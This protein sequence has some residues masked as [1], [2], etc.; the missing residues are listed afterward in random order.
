LVDYI[1]NREPF[2]KAEMENHNGEGGGWKMTRSDAKTIY[3]ITMHMGKPE[4]TYPEY[5]PS[6]KLKSFR[7]TLEEI[8]NFM[9][10]NDRKGFEKVSKIV[11]SQNKNNPRGSFLSRVLQKRENEILQKT[12]IPYLQKNGYVTGSMIFDGCMVFRK[13]GDV[14]FPK[15]IINGYAESVGLPEYMKITCKPMVDLTETVDTLFVKYRAI[16]HAFTKKNDLVLGDKVAGLLGMDI[17]TSFDNNGKVW[18][19]YQYNQDVHVWEET[20]HD[21]VLR[22]AMEKLRPIYSE[23]LFYLNWIAKSSPVHL[24]LALDKILK[25]LDDGVKKQLPK[26]EKI[27]DLGPIMGRMLDLVPEKKSHYVDLFF[28]YLKIK[29]EVDLGLFGLDRFLSDN[30]W[31]TQAMT[32]ILKIAKSSPKIRIDNFLEKVDCTP[33][34]LPLAS[35]KTVDLRDG[36]EISTRTLNEKG[37]YFTRY[38]KAKGLGKAD[39]ID[40][41]IKSHFMPDDEDR[42]YLQTQLGFCLTGE[43]VN[44]NLFVWLGDG[45]NGK[46]VL[47]AM[48]RTV[49][50]YACSLP[51]QD[52]I[53]MTGLDATRKGA[54]HSTTLI[55]LKFNRLAT[56][57]EPPKG[58]HF[59]S[60]KIKVLTGGDPLT[61]RDLHQ[62][63]RGSEFVNTCKLIIYTN[64]ILGSDNDNA[65]TDRVRYLN[66]PYRYVDTLTDGEDFEILKNGEKFTDQHSNEDLLGWLVEGARRY[67]SEGLQV[68]EETQKRM[69]SKMQESD[70]LREYMDLHY[71][72]LKGR[73]VKIIDILKGLKYADRSLQ[74]LN[75]RKIGAALR[76]I[77]GKEAVRKGHSGYLYLYDVMRNEDYGNE[78]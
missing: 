3:L 64:D 65:M 66:F 33:H 11:D 17:R 75:S 10:K 63:A 42:R 8:V 58:A 19:F 6:E 12:L 62:K 9:I 78:S 14:D 21:T 53:S 28:R 47:M 56:T 40:S 60:E 1:D 35:G 51:W 43:P 69:D 70:P 61:A 73:M 25:H 24:Q 30:I 7:E 50:P 20:S 2:L 34:L 76:R 39:R 23:M 4:N 27:K 55:P 5:I 26:I 54:E 46:S 15:K 77:Y 52:I 72:V 67:Y 71:K 45:G 59:I 74:N 36:S 37:I 32:R 13:S 48:V 68:P 31:T 18:S 44:R 22:V 41:Y 57:P 29:K 16:E 38:S 49:H